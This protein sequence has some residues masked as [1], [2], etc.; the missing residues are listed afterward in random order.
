M[1]SLNEIQKHYPESLHGFK[2][3]ML[4]EYLQYKILE[5]IFDSQFAN[6]LCF[7]GGTCLRIV[8]N[9]T[10]F[11]E[12][13][14]FDNFGLTQHDFSK[15]ALLIQNKL[16]QQGYNVEI[17]NVLSGA[18]HC[19]IRFPNL[20]FNEDLT[21]HTEQKILI[22]LDTEPQHFNFTPE[23]L[24]INKFDVF[25]SINITPV[26]LLLAQ[27]FYAFIN[28]KRKKGRDFFDIIFLLKTTRP[29]YDYLNQKLG[30]KNM[31]E[32]KIRILTELNSVN[33]KEMADDVSP[34]LFN[35][36]D[37]KQILM[38]KTYMEQLI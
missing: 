25:T 29:N 5:I 8:H 19:Y 22:Q 37:T 6:R 34:F 16:S 35:A 15:I 11:S 20:L 2:Q 14:D 26:D 23:Q 7:L 1:L 3:F 9:N 12:D 10:R 36:A 13:L 27:K 28:R 31:T 21:G 32:L 4:R 18:F 17:K 38:F 30:V 33:L 24:I